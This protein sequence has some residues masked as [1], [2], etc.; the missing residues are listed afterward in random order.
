MAEER[1]TITIDTEGVIQAETEGF[2]GEVC[3]SELE[4][5]LGDLMEPKKITKTDEYY[6]TVR[7]QRK[8][9]ISR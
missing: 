4:N 1:I 9:T 7:V 3:L 5:L 8:Q 6:Q 2:K